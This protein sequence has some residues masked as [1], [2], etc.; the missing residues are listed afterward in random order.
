LSARVWS[1]K[2]RKLRLEYVASKLE[3]LV[4]DIMRVWG[5]KRFTAVDDVQLTI[6]GLSYLKRKGQRKD[7]DVRA[8]PKPK[9]LFK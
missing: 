6:Y 5:V 7:R 3:D 2:D 8:N 4:E 9:R 1:H